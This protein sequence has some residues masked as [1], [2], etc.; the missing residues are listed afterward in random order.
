VN[1]VQKTPS[2]PSVGA[3]PVI[4]R[5]IADSEYA[6]VYLDPDSRLDPAWAEFEAHA[7]WL[8]QLDP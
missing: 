7:D 3:S 8:R 1:A 4:E 5:L 6:Q 2:D